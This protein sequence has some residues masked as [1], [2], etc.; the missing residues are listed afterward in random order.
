MFKS[1]GRWKTARAVA[2]IEPCGRLRGQ[3]ML[4]ASDLRL[5]AIITAAIAVVATSLIAYCSYPS[6]RDIL[7]HGRVVDGSEKPLVGVRLF[8]S[9]MKPGFPK[10]RLGDH[11]YVYTD[12]NGYYAYRFKQIHSAASLEMDEWQKYRLCGDWVPTEIY[13]WQL[14]GSHEVQKDFIYCV[15][16]APLK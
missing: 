6:A 4:D 2:L 1:G 11:A 15:R 7:V 8:V 3:F 13:P 12:A 16:P 5:V 9:D 14:L 10:E